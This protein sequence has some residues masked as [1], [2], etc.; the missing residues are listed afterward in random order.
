MKDKV[1]K[2]KFDSNELL[3]FL[4]YEMGTTISDEEERLVVITLTDSL[5]KGTSM[6]GR[7]YL[8]HVRSKIKLNTSDYCF[9]AR[10]K[11]KEIYRL[12]RYI[13]K[14]KGIVDV[15]FRE[16]V[17]AVKKENRKSW[18]FADNFDK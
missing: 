13:I 6:S 3:F 14:F 4:G 15:E 17:I 12:V 5:F 9:F 18:V 16:N 8:N 7:I 2:Y 11:A 1:L 10:F